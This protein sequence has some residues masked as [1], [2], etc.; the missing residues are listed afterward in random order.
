MK[1]LLTVLF[2]TVALVS[3]AFAQIQIDGDMLDWANIAPLDRDEVAEPVGDVANSDYHD[4]DLKHL[5]I[6]HDS[7]YVYVRIDLADDASFN[8]FYNFDNP[9]VFEFYMD[10][11]IGDTTGF[12]WGWWNNAYN[13]V[14]ELAPTLHPDSTVKYGQL[15][16]YNG[17]RIPTWAPGEFELLANIPMAIN[18][19]ANAMEFAIPRNLVNFGPEF[20]P[21]VYSVGNYQWADGADQ[22][23]QEGGAYMLRY[24]FWYRDQTAVIQAQGDQIDNRITIDGDMLDWANIPAADVGEIAE[25]IGDMPTGPEFDLKDIYV[26]SDSNNFYIKIDINPSGTFT[27]MYTNYPNPPAFQIF[28]NVNW[29][30]TTGLGYDGFWPLAVDYMV[31]LSDVLSPDSAGNTAA[32]YYYVAD[33]AGAYEE[34][35]PIDGAYA[36]FAVN[37]DDNSIE[38]AVPRTAI[39]AGTDIMPWVYVVG[40]DNWDNE[41]YWPNTVVQG[42]SDYGLPVYYACDYNFISGSSVRKIADYWLVTDVR[43]EN[44]DYQNV[45]GFGLVAN[46]PNPFNPS[47]IIT[48]QMSHPQNVTVEVYNTLGQKVTTLIS[49]QLLSAGNHQVRWNGK[50]AQGNSVTSGVYLYRISSPEYSVSKKMMLLK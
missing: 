19:D 38:V 50:D 31:D 6:T 35:Q 24:D 47:T 18:D 4:F 8:N 15:F 17:G 7:E 25:D 27:G 33:Y 23:P 32:I 13:Y 42:W 40:N 9:P 26:T 5:Y 16:K 36:T 46:Y 29:G 3:S 11:E 28:F 21:W 49:N 37:D 30:D 39:N 45:K 34:F 1:N 41:E 20:R 43:N 14:V 48:F 44:N 22:L 2:I 12:D 10:T